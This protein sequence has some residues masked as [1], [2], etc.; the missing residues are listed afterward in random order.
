[1]L[2]NAAVNKSVNKAV[3]GNRKGVRLFITLPPDLRPFVEKRVSLPRHA[4]KVTNYIRTLVAED[5]ERELAT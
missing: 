2:Q 4:G 3:N 1:M 5:Q